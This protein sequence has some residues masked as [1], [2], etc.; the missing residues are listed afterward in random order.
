MGRGGGG[1]NSRVGISRIREIPGQEIPGIPSPGSLAGSSG[2]SGL[3]PMGWRGG[4]SRRESEESRGS[5]RDSQ[6]SGIA[7]VKRCHFVPG[8]FSGMA[9]KWQRLTLEM[10]GREFQ[11]HPGIA[12]N[13]PPSPLSRES[14][15]QNPEKSW[16]IGHRGFSKGMIP[17]FHLL[18]SRNFGWKMWG[19]G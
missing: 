16:Q 12:G 5:R 10:P 18:L 17:L 3:I 7:R 4:N 13:S 14:P 8:D 1:G 15:S 19:W 11:Q 9:R 6:R 2:K